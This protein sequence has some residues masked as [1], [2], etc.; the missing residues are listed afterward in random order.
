MIGKIVEA[1]ISVMQ[2]TIMSAVSGEKTKRFLM[3]P[4]STALYEDT[5]P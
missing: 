3:I 5:Y 2:E 1:K 4:K